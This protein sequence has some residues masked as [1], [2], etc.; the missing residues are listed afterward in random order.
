MFVPI[1]ILL[2][3]LQTI[4]SIIAPNG[5]TLASPEIAITPPSG[6]KLNVGHSDHGSY[7][8]WD[9]DIMLWPLFGNIS[10]GFFVESG[11]ANGET[12]SNSLF[13][14]LRGWS[15]L[16]VEPFP[17]NVNSIMSKNRNV[18]TFAGALSPTGKDTSVE[19]VKK[20]NWESS[21]IHK[22]MVARRPHRP[23][24]YTVPATSLNTLMDQLGRKTIDFWS[25]DI[26]GFEGQVLANTNLQTLEIG[27]MLIEMNK[28]SNNNEDIHKIV[29]NAGFTKIGMTY[30][31][32]GAL[33]GIF[34]DPHY[35]VSRNLPVP[36]SKDFGPCLKTCKFR[37]NAG[38]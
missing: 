38:A 8:Q 14:E 16:L 3:S 11:A 12:C 23:R 15:G 21:S 29:S 27:V 10:N 1:A 20:G 9:Q 17:D 37:K 13:F 2:S 25:L 35:F 18:W 36:S 7:S 31:D 28:G 26:E 5:I 6:L 19:M 34:I 4:D 33:D 32:G 24:K 22:D 30:Y